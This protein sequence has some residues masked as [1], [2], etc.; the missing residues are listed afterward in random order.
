MQPLSL[1]NQWVK[2]RL[3]L[4]QPML[5]SPLRPLDMDPGEGILTRMPLGQMNQRVMDQ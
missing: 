3:G 2:D 4:Q 1:V 5:L